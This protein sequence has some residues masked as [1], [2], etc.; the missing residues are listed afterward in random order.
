ML[1]IR[2][3]TVAL[4]VFLVATAA[5]QDLGKREGTVG[6]TGMWPAP[7]AEDW[8]KPVLITFQRTWEDALAV[9]RETK[10]AILVCI[11]MDGEIASEHYAGVR[12]RQPEIAELYEPYVCVIASTY[13]HNP[14]DYDEQG[15][16]ILCPRFGSVT[17]GEHIWIEPIIFEK[18]LDGQRVAP[19]HIMVELD[20]EESYDIFYANDTITVFDTIRDGIAKRTIQPSTVVRGDRS[21]I[22][23]VTSPDV[24]DRNAVESAYLEG[25]RS[26]RQALLDAAARQGGKA[27]IDL[28]RLGVFGL[29]TEMGRLAR[30][31][32]ARSESPAA[33]DLIADAMRVPME[34]TEREAL[35]GALDRLGKDSVK[36]RWLAD[37]HRGL[38]ARSKAVDAESWA[39][40]R[41]AYESS[42][43]LRT[44][45]DL[46]A[47]QKQM[48]DEVGRSPE[49]VDAH[50]ELAEAS[51]ALAMK[52]R[53]ADSYDFR[54]AR[55][56]ARHMFADS[57][58][59]ALNAQKLGA[60]AW[61][62]N[63]ILALTAYYRG[64][65]ETAY[66]LAEAAV[67]E[68]PPG[69]PGWNAMAVLTIFGEGR[70][71]AIKK[72]A[73]ARERW[74]HRWLADL[75]A[76]YS[77]LLHHPL[78]TD[79]Q[80]LW[81]HEFLV[82]LG[83]NHRAT[84]VLRSGLSRF[85]D[86]ASL[87]QT[88]RK[89]VLKDR[90]VE[91]LEQTY[92][93]MLGQESAPPILSWYAGYASSVA[94]DFHRRLRRTEKAIAAYGR[95]IE[96]FDRAIEVS[97]ET[98]ESAD[99]YAALALAGL[100][101]LAYEGEDDERALDALV[102]SFARRPQAAGTKDGM[103]ITPAETAQMLITRLTESG[104]DDLVE[105]I[106]AALETVDPELLVPKEE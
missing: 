77:A 71:K 66:G 26:A 62:T 64:D 60:D 51:F 25:N 11:N 78:A 48:V 50:M 29:D 84:R 76:A 57:R 67:K 56:L 16:R 94:A 45:N 31:A 17:C 55:S 68:M 69:E 106:V 7:T 27:P 59:A 63:T 73:R 88:L 70:F 89:H 87:H 2:L 32:L 5:A 90:G 15:R 22:E 6:R 21:I 95:A 1:K 41:R 36:A 93:E 96:Y 58:H 18:F 24:Q 39:K 97:P 23:R 14:K 19:R 100:A 79:G 105:K 102:K 75:D 42:A 34:K 28:I 46:A 49:D 101:R 4:I 83:V 80:V 43:L 37:V 99:H 104:R 35:I 33:T 54:M 47:E 82:W 30:S 103:G 52:A 20:G 10:K 38:G 44:L 40:A 61:R 12:Y 92:G 98:R 86:S 91:A 65:P 3:L 13:R 74:P 8:K 85:P 9:S 81:Y 53:K 72:A